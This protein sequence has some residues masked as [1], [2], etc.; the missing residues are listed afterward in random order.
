MRAGEAKLP[1]REGGDSPLA[2]PPKSKFRRGCL[3]VSGLILCAGMRVL[4]C[5]SCLCFLI[6]FCLWALVMADV[7]VFK[8]FRAFLMIGAQV[9]GC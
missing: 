2:G 7:W 5:C 4:K 6:L 9:S 8:W 1:G 3:C